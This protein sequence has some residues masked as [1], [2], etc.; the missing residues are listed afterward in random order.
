MIRYKNYICVFQVNWD[1]LSLIAYIN[2]HIF[3]FLIKFAIP[4]YLHFEFD[5]ILEKS[6]YQVNFKEYLI[7]IHRVV[8]YVIGN[9][10][11]EV[12]C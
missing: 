10:V 8:D 2:R 5:L 12:F 11:N 6:D 3:T 9:Q 7:I 4:V 1:D